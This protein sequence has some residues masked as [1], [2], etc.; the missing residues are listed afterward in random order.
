MDFKDPKTYLVIA[1]VALATVAIARRIP[2][3]KAVV[4]V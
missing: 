2:Q 4:F 1:I 3:V